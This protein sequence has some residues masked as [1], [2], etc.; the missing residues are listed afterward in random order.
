VPLV[1]V[2]E[3]VRFVE[4]LEL[5]YAIEGLEPLAF[6]LGRLCDQLSVALERADRGAAEVTMRLRLV[7]RAMHERVLHLPAPMRDA[8]VLRTLL[9]LDAESHPPAAAIDIVEIEVAVVP[10]RIVQGSLLMRS[11]PSPETVTTLVA[12]L[13]ALMGETRVGA[14]EV[15]DSYDERAIT[16]KPFTA[17]P[18]APRDVDSRDRPVRVSLRRFRLPIAARVTLERGTPVHVESSARGIAA[19][20]VLACAGPSRSSGRWWSCDRSAWDRD[21]W[22]VELSDGVY[23]LAKNRTTGQWE[24]EGTL[25]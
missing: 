25:D 2:G 23:R 19:S 13:G 20:R 3:A 21:D 18:R 11:L 4:R 12:R 5:E 24:L 9:L 8:R 14:P 22:D 10:G 1:P 7:T 17:M 15:V 16:M 6:V